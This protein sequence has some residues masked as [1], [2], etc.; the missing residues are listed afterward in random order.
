VDLI[1]IK[2]LM[3]EGKK[4]LFGCDSGDFYASLGVRFY[5]EH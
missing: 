5:T 4:I 3:Y 2:A 1:K